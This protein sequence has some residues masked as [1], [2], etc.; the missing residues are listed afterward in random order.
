MFRI[1][2]RPFVA[3]PRL[4]MLAVNVRTSPGI[5]SSFPWFNMLGDESSL[6]RNRLRDRE[7]ANLSGDAIFSRTV[8]GLMLIAAFCID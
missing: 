8:A 2:R 6:R 4:K 1:R 5:T 3:P 7:N